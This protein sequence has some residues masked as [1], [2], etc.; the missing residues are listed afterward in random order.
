MLLADRYWFPLINAKPKKLTG[1]R[2]VT[3]AGRKL[4]LK[5]S[6]VVVGDPKL[7]KGMSNDKLVKSSVKDKPVKKS[8]TSTAD[9]SKSNVPVRSKGA[10]PTEKVPNIE[11]PRSFTSPCQRN[12]GIMLRVWRRN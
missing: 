9:K 10:K 7:L 12:L 11:T 2:W 1:G 5:G 6:K 4:Y 8:T 3:I